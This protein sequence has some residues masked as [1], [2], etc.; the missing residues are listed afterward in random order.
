ML[1]I[2]LAAA[3]TLSLSTGSAMA[4]SLQVRQQMQIAS[5]HPDIGGSSEQIRNRLQFATG[6]H[7]YPKAEIG[8]NTTQS[9][10][11]DQEPESISSGTEP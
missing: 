7:A 9:A 2:F 10:V 6:N 8:A 11:W 5:T 3:V 4:K 1:T